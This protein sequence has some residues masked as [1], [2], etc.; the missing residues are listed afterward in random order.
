MSPYPLE[1]LVDRANALCGE[2]DCE[3]VNAWSEIA[4]KL[5]PLLKSLTPEQLHDV[6][7][8]NVPGCAP[9]VY[10]G[11]RILDLV[12]LRHAGVHPSGAAA[13]ILIQYVRHLRRQERER[14][15]DSVPSYTTLPHHM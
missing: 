12:E 10:A 14:P 8:T 9:K 13:Q 1:D 11:G 3:D 6:F 15:R 2:L 5:Q 4:D 7:H